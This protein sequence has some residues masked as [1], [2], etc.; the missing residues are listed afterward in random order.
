M[1]VMSE[2]KELTMLPGNASFKE[3][4]SVCMPEHR[5]TMYADTHCML[6]LSTFL[7]ILHR[8]VASET[9]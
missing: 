1:H 5:H 3:R 7:L 8:P 9:N 6:A 2:Q 4:S